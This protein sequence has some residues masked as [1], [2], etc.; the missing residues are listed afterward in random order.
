MPVEK[1]RYAVMSD[2][3]S[4]PAALAAAV[5]DARRRGCNRF[6]MLG[7][8][9]GYGYDVKTAM[10][11]VRADFDIVLMGNHDSACLGLE[12]ER[13]VMRN[14]NYRVDVLQRDSLDGEGLKWLGGRPYLHVEGDA[15][16][17][18]GDFTNPSAWN[19]VFYAQDAI[20][21]LLSRRERILFCG[22]THHAAAWEMPRGGFVRPRLLRHLSQPAVRPDTRSFALRENCRYIVNVGSV[23]HPRCDRCST[24]AIY[25]SDA[26]RLSFRRLPVNLVEYATALEKAGIDLPLWLHDAIARMESRVPS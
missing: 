26:G 1:V 3:H 10:E 5:A 18:H 19:Y 7:D 17:V 13:E 14:R 25:D 2:V 23:G 8:V 24:Y 6:V 15:A 4:N 12:P 21:S 16:F 22:H 11:I 20:V 9:T